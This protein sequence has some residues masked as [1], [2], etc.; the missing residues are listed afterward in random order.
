MYAAVGERKG[1]AVR[2]TLGEP[3]QRRSI[4]A[5]VCPSSVQLYAAA[6]EPKGKVRRGIG[7]D[8]RHTNHRHGAH[9]KS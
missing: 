4:H 9:W 5:A 6:G 8:S 1:N 2:M 7:G 3:E